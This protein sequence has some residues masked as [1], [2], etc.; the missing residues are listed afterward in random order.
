L[1]ICQVIKEAKPEARRN[2][3]EERKKKRE[4]R[5][6]EDFVSVAATWAPPKIKPLN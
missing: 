6:K 1:K 5:K 3:K 4:E 2:T